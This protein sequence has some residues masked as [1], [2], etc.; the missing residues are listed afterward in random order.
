MSINISPERMMAINRTEYGLN[1]DIGGLP[2]TTYYTPDGRVI[3][4]FANMRE[5]VKK[6]DKG[7]VIWHG[8]VDANMDRGWLS[9]MPEVKKLYCKF[10]DTWHDTQVE[11]EACGIAQNK[12]L[13]REGSRARDEMV[14][15]YQNKDIKIAALEARIESLTKL[16]EKV[17]GQS[18]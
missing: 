9:K 4:A 17:L 14:Q 8:I 1:G 3:K 5:R 6:D 13:E 10:C 7:N 11:I 18:A 15:E 16:M 2:K 12:M